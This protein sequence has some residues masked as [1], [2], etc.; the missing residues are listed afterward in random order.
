MIRKT[1]MDLLKAVLFAPRGEQGEPLIQLPPLPDSLDWDELYRISTEQR[2]ATIVG[3]ALQ[4]RPD[5]GERGG[6]F[7]KAMMDAIGQESTIHFELEALFEAFEKAGVDFCPMKGIVTKAL[8]PL[9][10]MRVMSDADLLMHAE[11][12][13]KVRPLF[14]EQG[15][16]Y[17]KSIGV[18]DVYW[19]ASGL[20]RVEPH[21]RLLSSWSAHGEY[22]QEVWK[23]MER[24]V[25]LR[26]Q[27]RMTAEGQYLHYL[28]HFDKHLHYNGAYVR[29]VVDFTLLR[30][31]L[32]DRAA[33]A[34]R[35]IDHMG[36]ARLE[37]LLLGLSRA[38]FE[39]GTLTAQQKKLENYLFRTFDANFPYQ[40][41]YNRERYYLEYRRR[42]GET[43][44]RMFFPPVDKLRGE[45]PA[46]VQ[47]RWLTPL[48]R[49]LACAKQA[50]LV[51]RHWLRMLY[52]RMRGA[53]PWKTE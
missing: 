13:P 28:L 5:Y 42:N 50:A 45:Y 48:Y 19:N 51:A 37:Q 33:E 6:R 20:Y 1:L 26:H 14:E 39:G 41:C 31:Q 43:N 47:R 38:W 35:V 44:G 12:L 34:E 2:V 29:D 40:A 4:Q 22:N 17:E 9:P 27:Y 18:H 30:Q 32:G 7:A 49:V 15:F 16:A 8:Y 24:C 3:Y 25:P 53:F 46:I 10:W 11:D 21:S 52:L 36:L 23:H